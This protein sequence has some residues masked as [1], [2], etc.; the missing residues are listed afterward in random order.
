LSS[1]IKRLESKRSRGKI[2]KLRKDSGEPEWSSIKFIFKKDL[3]MARLLKI[4]I[5][6]ILFLKKTPFKLVQ[7]ILLKTIRNI[8][9]K[10]LPILFLLCF[11]S[12]IK[13]MYY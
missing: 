7:M 9:I 5:I 11:Y 4:P 12:I 13:V 1:K 2:K 6:K 10:K 8:S 3:I